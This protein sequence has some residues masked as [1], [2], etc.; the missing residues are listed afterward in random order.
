MTAMK[1]KWDE[2]EKHIDDGKVIKETE[3]KAKRGRNRM[4]RK[5][6]YG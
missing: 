5:M 6:R 1:E 3:R 2:K 4:E